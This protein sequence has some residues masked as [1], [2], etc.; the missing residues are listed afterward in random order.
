MIKFGDKIYIPSECYLSHG[1]DDVSGGLATVSK[2]E[3]VKG[4]KNWIYVEVKENP[5]TQYNWT[6][7]STQ[8][9]KLKKEFGKKKAYSNPDINR[10]W[11][12]DGDIVDG[13]VYHGPGIL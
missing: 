7:L 1:E 4:D 5:K 6:H 11:I 12:Q 13:I 3:K 2:V 9:K 8:Q 10:P